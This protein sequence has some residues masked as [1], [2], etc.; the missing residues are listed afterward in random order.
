[1]FEEVKEAEA[2]AE[3]APEAE[4]AEGEAK[5]AAKTE[6]KKEPEKK[7]EWVE[8]VKK[9]KR[10]KRTDLVI[11]RTGMLGLSDAE[12]QQQ[13]DI[14]TAMQAEM[15]EIIE[16]DEKRND[17][18]GYIFNMRDKISESGEYGAFI[19][20][21]DREK[22]ESD[23][24]KAEDWLYDF[25]GATKA[26]YVEKLDE[27]KA[28]GD[29][30]VWRFKEDGM[31]GE[32]IQA[33]AGTIGNYRNA[34]QN[35]GEKYGHI[36]IVA[37]GTCDR[38]DPFATHAVLLEAPDHHIAEGFELIKFLNVLRFGGTFEIIEPVFSLHQIAFELLSVGLRN[39]GTIL[40]GFGNLV[41]HVEN[42]TLQIVPLLICLDDLL[43][44]RLH[45][46]FYVHLLLHLSIGQTQHPGS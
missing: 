36:A 14:E 5:E 33:V 46:R 12:V 26:Q 23:L 20:Q 6:E 22:F 40:P 7:Y 1:V 9:K 17:L 35:P 13:M 4:A 42:I 41:A 19:S 37:D 24:M 15:K 8:V 43:H 16:T 18:E 29:V 31:R 28:L 11:S 38:L 30:V 3:K 34:V 21:A 2:P 32:W 27:L 44:L 39:E 25:E 10:P 45:C